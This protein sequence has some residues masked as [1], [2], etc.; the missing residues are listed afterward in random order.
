MSK[1][2]AVQIQEQK[3]RAVEDCLVQVAQLI[4]GQIQVQKSR[5]VE[6]SL[7][8]VNLLPL[9]QRTVSLVQQ[10]IVSCGEL[11]LFQ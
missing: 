11:N 9:R 5:G 8:Q 10:K 6:D 7:L 1:F 2:I 3:S 4:P